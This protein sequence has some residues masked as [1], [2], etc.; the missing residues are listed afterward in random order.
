MVK[1]NHS[2]SSM[3]Q[4]IILL[5][6]LF[7]ILPFTGFK[8]ACEKEIND[9]LERIEEKYVPDSRT[10]LFDVHFDGKESP[11]ITGETNLVN[12][13]NELDSILKKDH[14][15][16]GFNVDL[17]PSESLDGL[18]Y[19][20]IT[21]SVANLRSSPRHSAELITQGILGTPVRVLK[22]ENNWYLIQTPDSYL[23]WTTEGSISLLTEN[24]LENYNHSDRI[25]YTD[26]TG[27]CYSLPD[28]NS[29]PMSDIVAGSILRL[30]ER[31]AGFRKIQ[32]PD[33]RT[34]FLNKEYCLPIVKWQESL[35]PDERRIVETAYRFLGIPY[36][37]GGTSSKGLDCSGFTKTVFFMNGI[38]LQRDASQQVLYGDPVDTLQD[39]KYLEPADL[40]FFGDH[41]TDSTIERITHVGIYIGNGEFIHSSSGAGYVKINSLLP[42]LENYD[43]Y[44]DSIFICAR[45]ILTCVGEPGIE[46][47]FSNELY[48]GTVSQIYLNE[49]R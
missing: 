44:L 20:L 3:K 32:F 2:F 24:E 12:A 15:E 22:K 6:T 9:I 36:L 45:R 25:I 40:V 26:L 30:I 4:W 18:I 38:I 7:F 47:V 21:I 19:G 5:C 11:V 1:I 8:K 29:R 34:G 39:C 13:F 31:N 33:G 23:G 43:G 48:G 14:P 16:I 37:W 46:P 27:T 41:K 42:G 10:A 49:R 35:K 17:L 28:K